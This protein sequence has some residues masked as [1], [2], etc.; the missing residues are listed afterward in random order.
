MKAVLCETLGPPSS[1]VVRDLPEPRP[2]PGEVAVGVRA[3]ALNFFDTLIIEGKY[4]FKPQMPFSPGAEFCGTVTAVGEG[5]AGFAEGDLVAGFPGWGACR[6][7]VV[8][9]AAKLVHVP[10]GADPEQAAG[11]IVTYGTTLHALADRAKLKPGETLAVLG[12]SGGVGAAAVEIG[13]LL[14]ARVIAAASSPDKLDFCRALGADEVI[15]YTR[16][17]LKERLKELTGGRGVDVV[18]DPVGGDYAEPALRSMAWQGRYLVIGFAAGQIPKIPLNL[19][20]LKGCDIVGVFYGKFAEV[21]AEADRANTARL[22]GWLAEG[23]L[24]VAIHGRYP[25]ERTAE[26]L[27]ALARREIKGKA[28]IVMDAQHAAPR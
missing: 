18:Y 15:D 26:A 23:R 24:K 13:K 14:G 25:L 4:Q 7:T 5:V 22:L 10:A 2:G 28:V 20:L 11:L 17:D 19:V 21:E 3:A 27:E 12:A 16:E 8:V 9:P 6:E 1:L